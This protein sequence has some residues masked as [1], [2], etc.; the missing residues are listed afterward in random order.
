VRP[1]VRLSARSIPAI[2]FALTSSSPVLVPLATP[3]FPPPSLPI[4][5]A[6]GK[7]NSASQPSLSSRLLSHTSSPAPAAAPTPPSLLSTPA[8]TACFSGKRHPAISTRMTERLKLTATLPPSAQAAPTL[9]KSCTI[10]RTVALTSAR[11]MC[12][13]RS[14][15]TSTG[16]R[17]APDSSA[18]PSRSLSS[19][20][21]CTRTSL[22]RASSCA[23]SATCD[24]MTVPYATLYAAWH[25]LFA[26]TT[27]TPGRSKRCA[28][29][30]NY[31]D[32]VL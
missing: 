28:M 16:S 13:G 29:I 1:R 20:T 11:L 2:L 9:C 18:E 19:V 30:E 25:S 15:T 7:T 8:R 5:P 17:C 31:Q 4:A 14:P 10:L 6:A 23:P 3:T 26:S 32:I 27:P 22:V 24:P 21:R 12:S